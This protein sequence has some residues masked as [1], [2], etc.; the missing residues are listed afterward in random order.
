MIQNSKAIPYSKVEKQEH[1]VWYGENEFEAGDHDR[2][3]K[4]NVLGETLMASLSPSAR[5][6]IETNYKGK[7]EIEF[8]GRKWV[9]GPLLI[10]CVMQEMSLAPWQEIDSLK[11][12][13]RSAE[14]KKDIN[15]S[16]DYISKVVKRVQEL[17][18]VI[19]DS[20]IVSKV[21]SLIHI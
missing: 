19:H 12:Q 5:T 18:G 9:S 20:D 8:E 6:T 13:F 14:I 15:K 3:L 16:L 2:R 7:Y 17:G 11:E 1:R 10:W 21:L 4:S